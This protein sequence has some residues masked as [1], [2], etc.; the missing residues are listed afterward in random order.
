L[1]VSSSGVGLVT[2]QIYAVRIEGIRLFTNDRYNF[3]D[4]VIKSSLHLPSNVT[5]INK[6]LISACSVVS[7]TIMDSFRLAYFSGTSA[8]LTFVCTTSLSSGSNITLQFPSG[9]FDTSA[10][11]GVVVAAGSVSAS[12]FGAT[13]VVLTL[14]SGATVTGGV[15]YG[16]TLTGCKMGAPTAG[17]STGIRVST[18]QD[19]ASVGVASGAIGGQV[20]GVSFVMSPSDRVAGKTGSKATLAFTAATA[21]SSGGLITLEYPARFFDTSKFPFLFAASGSFGILQSSY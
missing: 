2:N 18:S 4:F 1:D 10:T 11:P 3:V 7:F 8:I 12:Q 15:S 9:F 16:V 6:P 20:S 14:G 13:S 5:R 17:S 21:L 19:F